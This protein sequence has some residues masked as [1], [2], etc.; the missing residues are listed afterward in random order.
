MP[1]ST[2]FNNI[3]YPIPIVGDTRWGQA[4]TNFLLA[5]G[6]N[7]LSKAGGNFSLTADVN[8]GANFGVIA[9]YLK[10]GSTNIAQSGVIRLANNEG[11]GFRS[12][13]NL[14]DLILKVNAS[15]QL[16]FNGSVFAS[17]GDVS[18]LAVRVTTA[19]GTITTHTA[20]IAAN[21]TVIGNKLDKTGDTAT[22]LSIADRITFTEGAAPA[23]PAAGKL[24]I[25]ADA[26]D[27]S[28]YTKDNSGAVKKLGGGGL[29]PQDVTALPATLVN[30]IAYQ[31]SLTAAS[32]A[33]LPITTLAATIE[34]TDVKGNCSASIYIG[35]TAGGTDTILYKGVPVTDR[36]VIRRRNATVRFNKAAGSSVWEVTYQTIALP[37]AGNIPGIT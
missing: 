34:V 33:L 37:T 10:S 11:F 20:Q 24:A 15:D 23:S 8:F 26:T 4:V 3:S 13:D 32:S 19:E 35:I 30:G 5:V 12:A 9:K 17:N 21:A 2:V 18:A 28:F 31:A 22:N 6:N 7:A 1:T 27:H 14:L 25:F 29:V 36:F 16:E